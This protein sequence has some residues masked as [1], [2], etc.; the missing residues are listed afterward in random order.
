MYVCSIMWKFSNVCSICTYF[1]LNTHSLTIQFKLDVL[2][3]IISV[4]SKYILT[5]VLIHLHVV[6]YECADVYMVFVHVCLY[7]VVTFLV[8]CVCSSKLTPLKNKQT[9]NGNI[10]RSY[11]NNVQ[12]RCGLI[13]VC[14]CA[15]VFMFV[16]RIFTRV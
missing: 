3:K 13:N 10:S 6:K 5:F 2:L 14:L 16:N 11:I 9:N 15:F 8:V 1:Y 4:P 12:Q 7:I